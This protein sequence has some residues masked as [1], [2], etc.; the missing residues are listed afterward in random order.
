[1]SGSCRAGIACRSPRP[2]RDQ[3]I[4]YTA[5]HA[6][7]GRRKCAERRTDARTSERERARA[8]GRDREAVPKLECE[9]EPDVRQ[10]V[11]TAPAITGTSARCRWH[12]DYDLRTRAQLAA[13]VHARQH[14][15]FVA[16][17]LP[18]LY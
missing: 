10:V 3:I 13:G 18:G 2:Q 16:V 11:P 1:M 8:A 12:H 6:C 14:T 17:Q 4:S 15:T 9:R 5:D 7:G